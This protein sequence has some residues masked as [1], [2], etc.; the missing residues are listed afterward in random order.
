[1]SHSTHA[2]FNCPEPIARASTSVVIFRSLALDF[3]P[4]SSPCV[5]PLPAPPIGVGHNPEPISAVRRAG[6]ASWNNKRP[7]GEAVIFQLCG[8][9][10]ETKANMSANILAND[11]ARARFSN[12]STHARLEV[13]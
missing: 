7:D 6:G 10:V 1:M 11:P 8:N 2:G 12:D 4:P 3:D 13:A 5:P 9:G